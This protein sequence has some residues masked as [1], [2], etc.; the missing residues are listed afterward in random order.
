MMIETLGKKHD[1]V[2]S[3]TVVAGPC[4]A[5]SEDQ[6][7]QTAESA[8]ENG[9]HL[10][11]AGLWKP[12]TSPDSW[13][14]A[15][16]EGLQWMRS[17]KHQFGIAITTEVN[18]PKTIESAM[19]ADFDVLWI[20]SRSA[21]HYPLLNEVGMQTSQTK[22]P[23]L[24]KRGMGSELAEWLSAA[25]YIR[26]WNH[27]VILCERGIKSFERSTRNTLDLQAAK[28]AQ[29]ESGLPVI[30]DV[31]HAAGRRDLILPMALAVKAAG[32][33]GLMIETHPNP[34]KARTD[35]K[36]QLP[37]D[38]FRKLMGKLKSIPRLV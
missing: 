37:L 17:A 35:S 31:S 19:N 10:F 14:G 16:E 6:I 25:D 30:V 3:W 20:G 18:S 23:V 33:D 29:M 15:G 27:N 2:N 34:N 24:L 12:R 22:T 11:R 13:Q 8:V 4:A 5:E 26:R 7:L 21:V 36:Q 32:L 9:A 28:L 1:I 38:D